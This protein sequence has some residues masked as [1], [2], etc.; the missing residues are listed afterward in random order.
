MTDDA[1]KIIANG[2]RD[3]DESQRVLSRWMFQYTPA[4]EIVQDHM[5][6]RVLNACAGQTRFQHTDKIIRKSNEGVCDGS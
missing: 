6:G 1:V 2:G 5:H 3:T 4:R